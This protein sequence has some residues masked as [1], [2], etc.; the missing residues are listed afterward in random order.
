M[1]ANDDEG[2]QD[3]RGALAFIASK[4]APTRERRIQS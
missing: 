1:D 4:L 2:C 3:K